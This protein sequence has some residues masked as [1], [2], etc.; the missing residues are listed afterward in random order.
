MTTPKPATAARIYHYLLGG[1]NYFPADRAAADALI[2]LHPDTVHIAR[3]NRAFVQRVVSYLASHGVR[4]FLDIGSGL[5][6]H[7]NVHDVIGAVIGDGHVVYVDVDPVVVTQHQELLGHHR[8]A[9]A[10]WGDLTDPQVILNHR[11]VRDLLSTTEPVGVLLTAVLHYL[12]D[13][14]AYPAVAHLVR[15]LPPASYLVISHASPPDE[16]LESAALDQARRVYQQHTTM[17]LHPRTRSGIAQF[18]QDLDVVDPGL[19]WAQQWRPDPS[20]PPDPVI[21]GILVA[22]AQIRSA[23]PTPAHQAD[24]RRSPARPESSRPPAGP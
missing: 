16:D 15:S 23:P 20:N 6:A 10:I 24:R 8:T 13:H 3:A 7:P 14:V 17:R 21:P 19:V 9:S 18:L 12:P 11:R 2:A 1:T 5:P 4:R 22:V